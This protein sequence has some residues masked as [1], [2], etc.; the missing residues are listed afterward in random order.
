[1]SSH[2]IAGVKPLAQF[3]D[4]GSFLMPE[5][6]AVFRAVQALGCPAWVDYDYVL[7]LSG[8]AVRLTWQQGWASYAGPA[9]QSGLFFDGEAF[10]DVKL[11][12]ARLGAAYIFRRAAEVGWDAAKREITESLDRGV[13]VLLTDRSACVL[14]Y[15]GDALLGVSTYAD[16][17]TREAPHGYNRFENWQNDQTTYCIIESYTPREMN[18]QLLSDTLGTAVKLATTARIDKL[19]DTA[20]GI[21]SFDALAEQLVWDE[22]FEPLEPGQRYEGKISF[23]YDRPEGYYREDGAR[24]LGN[25]FWD[26]Y[27]DFLCMLNGYGNFSRF[28]ER[29]AGVVPEWREKLLDAAKTYHAACE[30][31]GKLWQYVTPDDN[32]VAKFKDKDVRYAFAAHMLRAKIYTVRAVELLQKLV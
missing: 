6:P 5:I 23:P 27:C 16:P 11:A 17:N 10:T 30:F 7:S 15:D 28:L 25:R 22:S 4:D 24:T 2:S 1:M 20:L 32:G 26:G 9:N 14:G 12:L 21:S 13:P 3:M 18:R 31:S 8:A 19:G 29:Y